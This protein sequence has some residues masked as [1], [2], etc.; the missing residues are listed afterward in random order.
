LFQEPTRGYPDI[1]ARGDGF[2]S[3][4]EQS[5]GSFGGL[6]PHKSYPQFNGEG[7]DFDSA[8]KD[9]TSI[10]R[11]R[12]KV[13][14]LFPKS[15]RV[16]NVFHGLSEHTLHGCDVMFKVSHDEPNFYALT[17]VLNCVG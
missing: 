1:M 12:L 10:R 8:R 5:L 17:Y 4:V 3:F 2:T 11:I 9:D 6:E 14:N 16:G 15:H 13:D 7:N